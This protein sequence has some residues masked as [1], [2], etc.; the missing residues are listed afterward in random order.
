MEKSVPM[1]NANYKK[2][3]GFIFVIFNTFVTYLY[4][5]RN[6][7]PYNEEGNYFDSAANVVYHQQTADYLGVICIIGWVLF[8][9]FLAQ[10]YFHWCKTKK[11]SI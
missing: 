1:N 8:F 11:K 6:S 5:Q 4:I 3:I 7:L 9:L 2:I 10:Q